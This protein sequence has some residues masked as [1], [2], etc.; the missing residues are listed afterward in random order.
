M[1]PVRLSA[2]LMYLDSIGSKDL[3]VLQETDVSRP[4]K[5]AIVT[6]VNSITDHIVSVGAPRLAWS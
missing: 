5:T 4:V 2:Y 1:D 6:I 3:R